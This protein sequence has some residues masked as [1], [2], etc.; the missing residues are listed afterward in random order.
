MA[1]RNHSVHPSCVPEEFVV[2]PGTLSDAVFRPMET[3]ACGPGLCKCPAPLLTA[4]ES[5][6]LLHSAP[7]VGGDA[8]TPEP[9][10]SHMTSLGLKFVHCKG[11]TGHPPQRDHGLED[12]RLACEAPQP[13]ESSPTKPAPF[14]GNRAH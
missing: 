1:A 3:A 10:R 6:S 12:T 2:C 5:C 8:E 14:A 9:L 7:V 11:G 4:P 13:R